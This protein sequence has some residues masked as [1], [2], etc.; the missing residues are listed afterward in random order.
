MSL[1]AG[2]VGLPNVGKSTLLNALTDANALAANYPFATVDKNVG[3][4]VVPDARLDRLAE[5]VSPPRVV[6]STYEFID[7]AGLVK[8]ASRGEGL[9]NRFL[10]HIREVDA[11]IQ[12][13]RCFHDSDVPHVE[14]SVDALRDVEILATE[15]L[16]ADLEVVER[17]LPKI[18]K[19]AR[20]AVDKEIVREH[21][22]LER[23]KEALE[24]GIAVRNL[25]LNKNER[26]ILQP[27]G[28]LTMKPV[29]YVANVS[30][31]DLAGEDNHRVASLKEFTA[32]EGSD[33]IMISAKVEEE[34]VS[35][36]EDE[37]AEYLEVFD[38]EATGLER[39]V[40]KTYETLSLRTFFTHNEKEARGWTFIAGMTA[41]ECAGLV[42]TDFQ[43][44]FIKAEVIAFSDLDEAGSIGRAKETGKMRLEGK[45]YKVADGDIILFKFNV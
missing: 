3:T 6:P 41:Y 27:F 13:V 4:V 21:A 8:G 29:L 25:D 26:A 42:H 11:I 37:R 45:D 24:K 30:E 28:L 19:K 20:L 36:E 2:I 14:G 44:G 9:G 10:A 34:I 16:L 7:I 15:L 35:L 38:L 22:L 12:V 32:S 40:K 5:I 23:V 43:K 17:R 18:S 1:R 33:I 31:D 39:L